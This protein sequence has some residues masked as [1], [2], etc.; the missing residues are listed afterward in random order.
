MWNIDEGRIGKGRGNEKK[1]PP[2][3]TDKVYS[4]GDSL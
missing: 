2:E 1:T 4:E 3:C